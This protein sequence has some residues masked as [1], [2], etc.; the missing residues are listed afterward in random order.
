[1]LNQGSTPGTVLRYTNWAFSAS[2]L[3][4]VRAA[5]LNLEITN[6][7]D[8]FKTPTIPDSFLE[9]PSSRLRK[10]GTKVVD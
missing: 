8:R 9:Q 6:G 4:C 5:L 2:F 1:M 10:K 3:R 7:R